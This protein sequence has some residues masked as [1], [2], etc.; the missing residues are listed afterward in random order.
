MRF[1]RRHRLSWNNFSPTR[2]SQAPSGH[3]VR[4]SGTCPGRASGTCPGRASGTCPGRASGTCPGR[5]SG[6]CPGRASGTLSGISL[7]DSTGRS[8][9]R[10]R[11]PVAGRRHL[12]KR[13]FGSGCARPVATLKGAGS[14]HRT[15]ALMAGFNAVPCASA[16][17]RPPGSLLAW[18][19]SLFLQ[20]M[21]P[22][23]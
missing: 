14:P 18:N 11:N 13:C 2:V 5:A 12:P 23:P 17:G 16:P 4:A 22:E 6:T 21:R 8:T 3:A 20:V 10:P 9:H 15:P 19:N 1:W 7:F